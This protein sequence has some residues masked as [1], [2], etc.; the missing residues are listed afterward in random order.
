M[1]KAFLADVYMCVL[2]MAGLT[3]AMF[4][5]LNFLESFLN[6]P[7]PQTLETGIGYGVIVLVSILVGVSLIFGILMLPYFFYIATHYKG[8]KP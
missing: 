4:Q 6:S 2:M 8:D 7:A 5:D 1:R 3:Y